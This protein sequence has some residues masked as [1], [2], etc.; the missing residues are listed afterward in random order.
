MKSLAYLQYVDPR[1]F[2]LLL[3][4]CSDAGSGSTIRISGSTCTTR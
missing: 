4:E 3:N 1:E 2:W